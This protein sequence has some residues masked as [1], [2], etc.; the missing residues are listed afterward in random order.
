LVWRESDGEILATIGEDGRYVSTNAVGSLLWK[1]LA[2]GASRA[3]LADRIVAEFGIDEAD[4]HH[5]VEC[6]VA[7]LEKGGLLEV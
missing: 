2:E 1:M 6:F 7:D 5:D 4:A 3:E